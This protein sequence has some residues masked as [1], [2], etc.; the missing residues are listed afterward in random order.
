MNQIKNGQ[1]DATKRVEFVACGVGILLHALLRAADLLAAKF[2]YVKGNFV[3][4]EQ[5]PNPDLELVTDLLQVGTSGASI[6][7]TAACAMTWAQR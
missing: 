6:I 3:A 5:T 2:K 7:T 1:E 4:G